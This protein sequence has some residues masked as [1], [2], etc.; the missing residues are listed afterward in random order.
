MDGEWKL[1]LEDAPSAR[2]M[3]Q[4][5]WRVAYLSARPDPD[6]K[7]EGEKEGEPRDQVWLFN[8]AGGE[9]ERLTWA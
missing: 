4:G 2:V 9:P 1:A 8:L 3:R 6:Q 5:G 7:K